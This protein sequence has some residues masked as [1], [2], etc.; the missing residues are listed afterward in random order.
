MRSRPGEIDRFVAD[1]SGGSSRRIAD[2]VSA[3]ESPLKAR[4]PES[5]S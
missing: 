3:E 5:I 4:V 1:R 2:I